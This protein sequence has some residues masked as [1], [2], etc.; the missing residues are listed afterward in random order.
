MIT[1]NSEEMPWSEGMTVQDALDA[2]HYNYSRIIVWL[3]DEIVEDKA[4]FSK[5]KVPDGSRLQV[6]HLF[7]GG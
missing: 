6:I 5:I 4:S 1:V 3:N 7:A 2:C